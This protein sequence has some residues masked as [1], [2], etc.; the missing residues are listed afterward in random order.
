[1]A[2]K[3]PGHEGA[4]GPWLLQN[5]KSAEQV[6]RRENPSEMLLVKTD[7]DR[8]EH[9]PQVVEEQVSAKG[10]P[11]L[12]DAKAA[13]AVREIVEAG[14]LEIV[15]AVKA[16]VEEMGGIGIGVGR[17]V[18]WGHDDD[19]GARLRDPVHFRHHAENVGLV[20]QKMR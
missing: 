2:A 8:S 20:L 17:T 16:Q 7:G 12:Q 13:G 9:T 6:A 19:F 3:A 10:E 11:P 14:A 1:M 4:R 18:V 5:G 15:E